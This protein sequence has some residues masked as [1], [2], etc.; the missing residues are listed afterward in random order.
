MQRLQSFLG[1][2]L[3]KQGVEVID[4]TLAF[5]LMFFQLLDFK[6]LELLKFG[7]EVRFGV[8]QLLIVLKAFQ[9]LGPSVIRL[10]EILI[11]A[12]LRSLLRLLG[13]LWLGFRLCCLGRLFLLQVLR[14]NFSLLLFVLVFLS[15]FPD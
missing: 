5:A 11:H 3:F 15:H 1:G 4:V 7:G 8:T 2:A 12:F 10:L 13:L 9:Q 14:L 6:L